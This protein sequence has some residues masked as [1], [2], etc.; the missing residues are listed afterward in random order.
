[1][2]ASAIRYEGEGTVM[3]LEWDESTAPAIGDVVYASST[4]AKLNDGAD[5]S[6]VPFVVLN[7]ESDGDDGYFVSVTNDAIIYDNSG[8]G[9][10]VGDGIYIDSANKNIYQT[11]PA[12]ASGD[13]YQLGVAINERQAVIKPVIVAF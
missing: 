4:G 10:A 11:A 9:F 2:D 8:A 3:T 7:F 1:M 12:G 13:A 5:I 6:L